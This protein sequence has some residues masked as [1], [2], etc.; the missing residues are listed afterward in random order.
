MFTFRYIA[1]PLRISSVCR[2]IH[3]ALTG[4][5]A[6]QR[7]GVKEELLNKVWDSLDRCW[8]ELE[9]LRKFGTG[10]LIEV[11]DMERFIHGWQVRRVVWIAHGGLKL[12]VLNPSLHATYFNPTTIATDSYCIIYP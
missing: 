11:E 6:K 9:D 10:D 8:Q 4:P 7:E 2:I 5:K 3:A 12:I 1:V